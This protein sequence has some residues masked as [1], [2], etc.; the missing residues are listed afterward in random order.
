[1]PSVH[2]KGW[3][4]HKSGHN[5]IISRM[6]KSYAT[7]QPSELATTLYAVQRKFDASVHQMQC[8]DQWIA[9]AK[10]RLARIKHGST[11]WQMK[12][13]QVTTLQGVR[14]MYMKFAQKQVSILDRCQHRL[15]ELTALEDAGKAECV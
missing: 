6:N 13:Q 4:D 2:Y 1:M 3:F 14:R 15:A 11:Y 8:I 7:M 9:D 12:N 10:V 5:Q